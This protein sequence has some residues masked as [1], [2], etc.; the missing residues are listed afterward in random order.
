MTNLVLKLKNSPHKQRY[1]Y[2][3]RELSEGYFVNNFL[4]S[5]YDWFLFTNIDD[6]SDMERVRFETDMQVNNRLTSQEPRNRY[7][8]H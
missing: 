6:L 2:D 3:C 1:P 4:I 8:W 7:A 5:A